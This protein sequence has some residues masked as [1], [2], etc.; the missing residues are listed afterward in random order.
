MFPLKIPHNI[1]IH[2]H[3]D[4]AV[5]K[6]NSTAVIRDWFT[7][8]LEVYLRQSDVAPEQLNAIKS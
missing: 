7:L 4:E 6:V 8:L 2:M 3:F 1:L 5:E